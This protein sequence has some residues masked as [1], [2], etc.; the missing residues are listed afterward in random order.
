MISSKV[1]KITLIITFFFLC[2]VSICKEE[3]TEINSSDNLEFL[4][5][6]KALKP[7]TTQ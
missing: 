4:I 5:Y 6:S 7:T 2:Q 1:V 3:S